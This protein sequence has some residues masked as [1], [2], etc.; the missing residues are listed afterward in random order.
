MSSGAVQHQRVVSVACGAE[1]TLAAVDDG[2]VCFHP[3]FL[4]APL[5]SALKAGTNDPGI[6]VVTCLKNFHIS[7]LHVLTTYDNLCFPTQA[8]IPNLYMQS[9]SLTVL[10]LRMRLLVVVLRQY[11]QHFVT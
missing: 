7:A 1:H 10:Y 9:L 6:A 8:Y 2:E 4:S 3:V 5:Q 11:V